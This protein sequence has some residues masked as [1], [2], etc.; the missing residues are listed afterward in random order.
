MEREGLLKDGKI[1][2]VDDEPDILET[3]E[4]L[5]DQYS[6]DTATSYEAGEKLL[7]HNTYD[8]AI[9][10]IMG[11]RG[12][13]LLEIAREK[14]IPAL[15]LTAH[16]LSAENLKKSIQKGADSYIPKDKLAD[17]ATYVEDILS[18]NRRKKSDRKSW[19]ARLKPYFDRTFRQGWKDEDRDFWNEFDKENGISDKD[20]DKTE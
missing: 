12:Y 14:D 20:G 5:L 16:A 8:L 7:G 6:L 10:D 13:D 9:L 4:E 1:L 3:I 11:V 19:F 2:V 15:M 18:L 17:I